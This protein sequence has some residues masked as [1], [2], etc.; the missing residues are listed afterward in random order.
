[1]VTLTGSSTPLTLL[2]TNVLVYAVDVEAPH[3]Y[4]SK[5]LLDKA[6]ETGSGLCVAPQNFAEFLAIVTDP[7]R[8]QQ[9]LANGTAVETVRGFA[10]LPG[11]TILPVPVDI[12][13]RFLGLAERYAITRQ[14]V[15]D[16]Y[17]VATMLGNGVRR[18]HTFNESDFAPFA[19]IEVIVPRA[20]AT[21]G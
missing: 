16:A 20:P 6:G 10:A 18:I 12:L 7:R 2:D 3:H 17:L 14:R 19:E 4:F 15:F 9:P 5:A 8:V 13:R 21:K 11:L 1:M